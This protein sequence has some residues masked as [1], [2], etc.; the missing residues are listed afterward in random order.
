MRTTQKTPIHLPPQCFC[1]GRLI[2]I[3][4]NSEKRFI[5]MREKIALV[6]ILISS[7]CSSS[8]LLSTYSSSLS[9]D[10]LFVVHVVVYCRTASSFIFITYKTVWHRLATCMR[11]PFHKTPPRD[12]RSAPLDSRRLLSTTGL[13]NEG[14]LDHTKLRVETRRQAGGMKDSMLFADI[15]ICSSASWQPVLD[16]VTQGWL[17]LL[18]NTDALYHCYSVTPYDLVAAHDVQSVLYE[19]DHS[20]IAFHQH[21][22]LGFGRWLLKMS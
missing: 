4:D 22:L 9:G 14:D 17:H 8:G 12:L 2:P 5:D 15:C 19:R 6:C 7:S 13:L 10:G 18:C 21:W 16:F 11:L 3:W 1:F 20:C